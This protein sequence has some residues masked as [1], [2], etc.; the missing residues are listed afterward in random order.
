[1]S[2]NK[3]AEV[4][5]L[6]EII[7][8]AQNLEILNHI[9]KKIGDY[10]HPQ[11][12]YDFGMAFFVKG[13]TTKAKHFLLKGA[14]YGLTYD[15]SFYDNLFSDVIGQCISILLQEYKI[16]FNSDLIVKTTFL[17]YAYL[18]RCIEL[19]RY[20]AFDSYK[21]R[22]KLFAHHQD[23]MI[24]IKILLQ[25]MGLGVKAEPFIISDYYYAAMATNSPHNNFLNYANKIH[26]RLGDTTI[27]G[28]DA[29]Q[30]TL[31]ELA[32]LGEKRHNILFKAIEPRF[33]NGE[34]DF[35]KQELSKLFQ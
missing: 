16:P 26:K 9:Y 8:N 23:P 4:L 29:D 13:E 7:L 25:N 31:Q 22:G 10:Q 27:A 20:K 28:K 15:P 5:A 33:K 19:Y 12:L 1:M 32:H 2:Q 3:D 17:G 14:E 18:S 11:I 30:Y 24:I 35:T 6:S 21:T 34:F